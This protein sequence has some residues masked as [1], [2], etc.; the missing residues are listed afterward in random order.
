M[1]VITSN[2]Y[3]LPAI[4]R[5]WYASSLYN[6][7]WSESIKLRVRQLSRAQRDGRMELPFHF[8]SIVFPTVR[9]TL[10]SDLPSNPILH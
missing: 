8:E 10:L 5:P 1:L 4:F 7:I 9:N 2:P 6:D 3:L